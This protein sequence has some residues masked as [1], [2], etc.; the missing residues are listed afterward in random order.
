MFVKVCGITS[1]EQ[2][3]WAVDEGYSAMGIVMH[4]KSPRYCSKEK[5][6]SLVAV[7]RRRIICFGVALDLDEMEGIQGLFDFVQ[8]YS[9]AN[10][11]NLVYAGADLPREKLPGCFIYDVS[12]GSGGFE[13][14]P[15]WVKDYRGRLIL[16]GGLSAGNV[17]GVV[18]DYRPYGVDVS[19]GVERVPGVKDRDLM[20]QFISEVRN[21]TC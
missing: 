7:A 8:L 10:L 9:W 16:S 12:R 19:S 15:Q 13:R 1:Y 3:D 20:R 6:R 2:V 18:R 14:P 21:G 17:A 4:R 11:E 5:A